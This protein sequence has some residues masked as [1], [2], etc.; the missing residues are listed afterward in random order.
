MKIGII[1]EYKNPPDR[2]VVFSP[3]KCFCVRFGP[4][5]QNN[6]SNGKNNYER[7]VF[8]EEKLFG[9]KKNKNFISGRAV[10]VVTGGE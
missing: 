2:R 5:S 8:A 7:N 4:D 6:N 3:S 10:F 1:K 9:S